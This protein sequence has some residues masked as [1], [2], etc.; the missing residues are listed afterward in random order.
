MPRRADSS[1]HDVLP[2]S[3][4]I[5]DVVCAA[6]PRRAVSF[7]CNVCPFS[8]LICP[9]CLCCSAATGRLI[10][11]RYPFT[12]KSTGSQAP[13]EVSTPARPLHWRRCRPP[14]ERRPAL[15]LPRRRAAVVL[16]EEPRPARVRATTSLLPFPAA[17]GSGPWEGGA[18]RGA[19]R[20]RRLPA[21]AAT[22][23]RFARRAGLPGAL[24]PKPRRRRGL[25][26]LLTA[27]AR[28][29]SGTA[30]YAGS[31]SPLASCRRPRA[32]R[33]RLCGQP[34]RT[35]S[36]AE[37]SHWPPYSCQ[38]PHRELTLLLRHTRRPTW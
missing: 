33:A 16:L 12:E 23:R 5:A 17:P 1:L 22:P 13:G 31:R 27:A 2:L 11:L 9:R 35:P 29:A 14:R 21:C 38:R 30:V 25:D 37:R 34:G 19:A 36:S 20:S 7:P 6:L 4:L 8:A 32:P 28:A 3:A 15:H 26:E 24:P 10:L 18:S